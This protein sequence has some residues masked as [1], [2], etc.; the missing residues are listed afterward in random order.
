MSGF[1][2]CFVD[3]Y[4]LADKLYCERVLQGEPESDD[5]DSDYDSDK[6]DSPCDIDL[7]TLVFAPPQNI[8]PVLYKNAP[9]EIERG[10]YNYAHVL[11]NVNAAIISLLLFPFGDHKWKVLLACQK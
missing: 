3:T 5:Y 8:N 1:E 11:M 6:E 10:W 9:V 7:E 4:D 2:I